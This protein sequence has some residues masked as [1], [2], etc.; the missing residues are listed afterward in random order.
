MRRPRRRGFDRPADRIESRAVVI[1]GSA[2]GGGDA[3]SGGIFRCRRAAEAVLGQR[4]Q[5]GA[6]ERG[7]GSRA[8]PRRSGAGGAAR[9]PRDGR[10]VAV[11]SCADVQAPDPA[12]EPHLSDE[13]T[14]YL[15]RDRLSFMRFRGLGLADTLPDANTIRSFREAL[16]RARIAGQPAIEALVARFDAALA[17]AGFLAMSGRI[18]DAS[19]IAAPK[20]R[21]TDGEKAKS[22]GDFVEGRALITGPATPARCSR[23]APTDAPS[24]AAFR[25]AARPAS[26]ALS[27][28]PACRSRSTSGS[29][30]R[31]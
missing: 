3:R 29:V 14:E 18:I 26:N 16:T 17:A 10:P 2:L 28:R 23:A 6:A 11:R 8:V 21:N 5:P 20:Q 7:G 13:R 12:G 25:T 22:S 19:I 31:R 27:A 1:G 9:G 15:I 4:R 30:R 24:G